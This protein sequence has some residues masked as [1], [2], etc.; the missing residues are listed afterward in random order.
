MSGFTDATILVTGGAGFVGTALVRRLLDARPARIVLDLS[1][2][3]SVLGSP[4]RLSQVFVNLLANSA[5]ALGEMADDGR[6]REAVL[7]DAPSPRRGD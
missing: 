6:H 5:Q 2:H 7:R 1:N 3:A 4:G